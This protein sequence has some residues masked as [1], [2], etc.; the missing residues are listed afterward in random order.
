L[1]MKWGNHILHV[2]LK[3]TKISETKKQKSLKTL[4][5]RA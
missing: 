2:F 4:R 3:C 1:A 5:A